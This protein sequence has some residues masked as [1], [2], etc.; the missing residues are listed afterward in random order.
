MG[1]NSTLGQERVPVPPRTTTTTTRRRT[2]RRSRS[3][4]SNHF[5]VTGAHLDIGPGDQVGPFAPNLSRNLT[6]W[7]RNDNR[8]H[9]ISNRRRIRGNRRSTSSPATRPTPGTAAVTRDVTRLAAA[10]TLTIY[11]AILNTVARG[12]ANG[13]QLRLTAVPHAALKPSNAEDRRDVLSKGHLDDP[14]AIKEPRKGIVDRIPNGVDFPIRT[15]GSQHT[16]VRDQ[17]RQVAHVDQAG[18]LLNSLHTDAMV[19]KLKTTLEDSVTGRSVDIRHP[20]GTI[21]QEL[22]CGQPVTPKNLNKMREDVT[23]INVL[24]YLFRKKR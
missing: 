16:I 19:T 21:P 13:A 17:T 1:A 2:R 10:R 11:R 23:G 5:L 12:S 15:E 6:I 8:R 18:A 22:H 24:V 9:G 4:T 20:D 3:S 7:S 14:R